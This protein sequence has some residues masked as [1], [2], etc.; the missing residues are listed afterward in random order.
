MAPPDMSWQC[1]PHVP[2][3][4]MT[5]FSNFIVLSTS[6]STSSVYQAVHVDYYTESSALFCVLTLRRVHTTHTPT[7]DPILTVQ[8]GPCP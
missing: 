8:F 7:Q 3:W 2:P 5:G 4:T 1:V 6:C